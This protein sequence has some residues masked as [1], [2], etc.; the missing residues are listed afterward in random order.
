MQAAITFPLNIFFVVLQL[1]LNET[2]KQESGRQSPPASSTVDAKI[3][4]VNSFLFIFSL[5][6]VC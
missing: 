4:P 5:C 6:L 3:I 2:M 1:K